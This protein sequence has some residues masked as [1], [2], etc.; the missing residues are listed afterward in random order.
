[1]LNVSEYAMNTN[2]IGLA[3]SKIARIVFLCIIEDQILFNKY[4]ILAKL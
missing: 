4:A 3:S 2:R 1:M